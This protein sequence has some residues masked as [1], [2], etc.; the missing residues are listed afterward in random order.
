M[1]IQ[2]HALIIAQIVRRLQQAAA[3]SALLDRMYE[4]C[5]TD[6]DIL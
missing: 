4:I 6:Y 5:F 3:R 1:Q 2:F